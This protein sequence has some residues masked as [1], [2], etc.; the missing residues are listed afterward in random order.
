[1][2]LRANARGVYIRLSERTGRTPG[3]SG[4]SDGEKKVP[5][6]DSAAA[7][8]PPPSDHPA[9]DNS[10]GGGGGGGPAS[11]ASPALRNVVCIPGAAIAWAASLLDYYASRATEPGGG[12]AHNRELPVENKIC[13]LCF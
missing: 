12:R 1:V 9:A 3:G 13:A 4:T 10:A 11:S 2:D 7:V 8:T 5:D 6:S